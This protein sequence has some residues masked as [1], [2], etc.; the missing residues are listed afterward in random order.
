METLSSTLQGKLSSM[1]HGNMEQ[2]RCL[3]TTRKSVHW[4]AREHTI[5]GTLQKDVSLVYNY[6]EGVSSYKFTEHSS[7]T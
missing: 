5:S 2:L 7:Y 6:G 3:A 4:K 1:L